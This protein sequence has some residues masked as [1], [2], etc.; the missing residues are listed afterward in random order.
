MPRLE[1][2]YL[3]QQGNHKIAQIFHPIIFIFFSFIVFINSKFDRRETNKNIL[4][5]TFGIISFQILDFFLASQ[6][7]TNLFAIGFLYL[8]PLLF[9]LLLF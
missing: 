9:F 5:L 3:L 4:N 1:K 7:Q 2:I 8:L 6:A